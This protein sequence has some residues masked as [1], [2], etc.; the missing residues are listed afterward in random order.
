MSKWWCIASLL[1]CLAVAVAAGRGMP[2]RNDCDTVAVAAGGNNQDG[3]VFGPFGETKTAY[4]GST[5]GDGGLFG[6]AV[7]GGPLGGGI[8]GFGP[9]GGFG[10]GAGPFGGFGGGFGA[11]GGGGGGGVIP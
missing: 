8:A 1:M 5:G 9:H 4:A 2:G 11:G 3:E 10:A 6:G 7:N